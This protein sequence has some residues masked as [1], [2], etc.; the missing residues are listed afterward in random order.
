MNPTREEL[1]F[2]LV[3]EKPAKE[4]AAF[5]ESPVAKMRL[6]AGA[7]KPCWRRTNKPKVRL[8]KPRRAAKRR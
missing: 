3:L 6:C 4:R 2:A 8:P 7:S 5:L 1:L